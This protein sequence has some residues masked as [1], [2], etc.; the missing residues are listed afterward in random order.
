MNTYKILEQVKVRSI[1]Q[2]LSV[3]VQSFQILHNSIRDDTI[4][5]NV[6]T[7]DSSNIWKLVFLNELMIRLKPSRNLNHGWVVPSQLGRYRSYCA[8]SPAYQ[9]AQTWE[10]K[11]LYEHS[12]DWGKYNKHYYYGHC[13][14]SLSSFEVHRFVNWICFV[15]QVLTAVVMKSFISFGI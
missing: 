5:N 14:Y 1:Y 10:I 9:L 7:E 12:G 3:F 2:Y 6:H 13:P 4:R 8:H 11:R 15:F